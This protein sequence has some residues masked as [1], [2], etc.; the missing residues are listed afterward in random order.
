MKGD[1]GLNCDPAQGEVKSPLILWGPYLW[2]DGMKHRKSDGQFWE[3]SDLVADGTH[4]S[5]SGRKKVAEQL[6][7]FFKTDPHAQ[8]WF[9]KKPC[10]P[11]SA[12]HFQY[13]HSI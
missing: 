5:N 7:S 13:R 8:T 4:P 3:R 2:S 10:L 11:G 1:A 9:V 12:P 6:L